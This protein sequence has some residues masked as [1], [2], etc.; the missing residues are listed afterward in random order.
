M[1]VF[2]KL[3]EIHVLVVGGMYVGWEK[4]SAILTNSPQTKVR[5]VATEIG[6]E[7]RA[8]AA[9]NKNVTLI[10]RVFQVSDLEG[11]SLVVIGINDI[12]KSA[13]IREISHQ[14]RLLVN[15][16]DKPSLCDFY[17]S[18]VVKKGDLK[19]A[20]STNGKSPTVAKRIKEF[21]NESIPETI[22]E[23]LQNMTKIREKLRGDFE[24]KV[25]KLNEV[26][27]GWKDDRSE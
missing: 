3:E 24:Y 23:I 8:L 25:E 18:S 13:E 11:I 16:A 12:E 9:D 22:D 21:L 27:K 6:S 17:L 15:V 4:L 5:L 19:I 14:Q 10:E 26:T 2:L 7:V 20:I 1:P